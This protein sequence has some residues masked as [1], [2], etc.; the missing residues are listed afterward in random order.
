[1]GG[2]AFAEFERAGWERA[3]PRYEVCWTDTVLFVEAL[4]DAAAVRAGSGLL[5]VACG[6]GFV[7]EAAAAR[8]AR[9]VGVD[10]AAAMVERARARCPDLAFVVGDALRLPFPDASFDAVTI[11]FGILHVFAARERARRGAP[12]PR[13]GRSACVHDMAGAGQRRG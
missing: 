8:G 2:V 6:P 4:L 7:S 12:G 11:N 5:D 1:M 3:A 13:S 10:V 9:P